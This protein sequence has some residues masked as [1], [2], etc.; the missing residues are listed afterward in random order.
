MA[1]KATTLLSIT[2][3]AVTAVYVTP[4]TA[5]EMRHSTAV[6]FSG[7]DFNRSGDVTAL[8]ERITY[9]AA[10]VC[11]PRAT[12]GS[13]YTSSGYI[14]CYTKALDR[15]IARVNRPELTALYKEQ[16]ARNPGASR[17]VNE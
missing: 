14:R 7:V 6:Y 5:D 15:A 1:L 9:A 4:A 12:T 8:Y 16:L 11:G 13:Y 3:L 17:L 10:Q 2:A